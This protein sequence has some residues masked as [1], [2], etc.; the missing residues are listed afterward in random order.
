MCVYVCVCL[1][2]VFSVHLF[3]CVDMN[4]Y[5]CVR[6]MYVCMPLGSVCLTMTVYL[7]AGRL[8]MGWDVL[9]A[10]EV[11]LCAAVRLCGS[12]DHKVKESRQLLKRIMVA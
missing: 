5:V 10:I 3:I 7:D 9:T 2:S 6:S 8:E 4:G 12:R 11:R 1:C